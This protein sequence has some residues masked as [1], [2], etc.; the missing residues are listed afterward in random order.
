MRC[1]P[2]TDGAAADEISMASMRAELCIVSSS[3][4]LRDGEFCTEGCECQ[5]QLAK[6]ICDLLRRCS[7]RLNCLT[8]STTR[9][10]RSSTLL[11]EGGPVL[12][13]VPAAG[14]TCP[15][16]IPAAGEYVHHMHFL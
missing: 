15:G 1:F 13:T 4:F 10:E 2:V 3:L 14:R 12:E 6:A 8:H 9:Q 16:S 5:F 7:I 11:S